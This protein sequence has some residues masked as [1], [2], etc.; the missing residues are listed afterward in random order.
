MESVSKMLG[1]KS[2]N[3]TQIYA[4]AVDK[5]MGREMDE[6]EA[7]RTKLGAKK[8]KRKQLWKGR[9][10][11]QKAGVQFAREYSSKKAMR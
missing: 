3:T 9:G 10:R 7:L 11:T 1:H 5:K 6:L 8:K 4:K 2:L